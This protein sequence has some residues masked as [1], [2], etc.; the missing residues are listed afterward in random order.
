MW[1]GLSCG[2]SSSLVKDDD[3]R[4]LAIEDGGL[5]ACEKKM[6]LFGYMYYI[7]LYVI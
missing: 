3:R 1:C 6:Y 7:Y 4:P 5:S 2:W